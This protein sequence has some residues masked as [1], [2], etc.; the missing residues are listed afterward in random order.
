MRM[1]LSSSSMADNPQAD[2][3]TKQSGLASR[4]FRVGINVMPPARNLPSSADAMIAAA[5]SMSLALTYFVEYMDRLLIRLL[6]FAQIES[7]AKP[8]AVLLALLCR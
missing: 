1:A 7:P 2:R 8:F 6:W 4:C 3:S 5:S